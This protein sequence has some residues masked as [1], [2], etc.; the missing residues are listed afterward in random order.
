MVPVGAG[1]HGRVLAGHEQQSSAMACQHRHTCWVRQP[2]PSPS[3][4]VCLAPSTLGVRLIVM[5]CRPCSQQAWWTPA[6]RFQQRSAK[7][8]VV[9]RVG[10]GEIARRLQGRAGLDGGLARSPVT[11]MVEQSWWNPFA[12]MPIFLFSAQST[13]VQMPGPTL[14]VPCSTN[15]LIRWLLTP[16]H[17]AAQM[18]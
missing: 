10:G 7:G 11:V 9:G 1:F 17:H 15:G 13:H 2:M 6:A 4:L 3:R 5:R 8:C 14:R 18:R 12:S 16:W